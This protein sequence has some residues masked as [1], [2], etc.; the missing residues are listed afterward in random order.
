MSGRLSV[1]LSPCQSVPPAASHSST[2]STLSRQQKQGDS[3]SIQIYEE[4]SDMHTE[5]GMKR[6]VFIWQC[7]VAAR[8]GDPPSPS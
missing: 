1:S 5:T 7:I 4:G 3:A 6:F 2:G 8:L